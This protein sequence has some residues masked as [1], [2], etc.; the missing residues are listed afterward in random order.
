MGIGSG[1]SVEQEPR[2]RCLSVVHVEVRNRHDSTAPPLRF[3][4]P[5]S[6]FPAGDQRA[7][8]NK[9]NNNPPANI[10]IEI[11]TAHFSVKR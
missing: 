8:G 4:I 3:P 11:S 7:N 6:P 9:P 5:D 1:E 10:S 2:L